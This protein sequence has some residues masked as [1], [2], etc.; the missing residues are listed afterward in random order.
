MYVIFFLI[1]MYVTDQKFDDS[2]SGENNTKFLRWFF[3]NP[4]DTVKYE[5]IVL[6]FLR[7]H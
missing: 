1:F 3:T 6:D 5:L 4:F 7:R 2:V